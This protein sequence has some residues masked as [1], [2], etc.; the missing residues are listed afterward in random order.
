M[1][2]GLLVASALLGFVAVAFSYDR[3]LARRVQ[4]HVLPDD[5]GSIKAKTLS[6]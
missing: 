6:D 2:K 5:A 4:R 1:K 3:E